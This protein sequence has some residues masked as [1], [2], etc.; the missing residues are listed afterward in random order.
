MGDEPPKRK[1]HADFTD[2]KPELLGRH[3]IIGA[4]SYNHKVRRAI[5]PVNAPLLMT[6]IRLLDKYKYWRAVRP[7]NVTLFTMVIRLL[8]KYKYWRVRPVN[9]P[10]MMTEIRLLSNCGSIA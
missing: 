6:E 5:R 1:S 10:L 3:I 8:F 4:L 2:R 7:V 9:A